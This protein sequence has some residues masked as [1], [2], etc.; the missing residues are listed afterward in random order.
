MSGNELSVYFRKLPLE[1]NNEKFS[2]V[3]VKSK[4][5]R[6][7]WGHPGGNLLRF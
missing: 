1:T 7:F 6:A 2:L 5:I 4:K 3:R